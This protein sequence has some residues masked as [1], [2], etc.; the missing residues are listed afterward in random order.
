MSLS[1]EEVM[2][3]PGGRLGYEY[4]QCIRALHDFVTDVELRYGSGGA[5][6][7]AIKALYALADLAR[8]ELQEA[9]EWLRLSD[10][11]DPRLAVVPHK[12]ER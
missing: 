1:K 12:G 3:L 7:P 8:D 9:D 5:S 4:A 2:T 10:Y 11:L 6:H